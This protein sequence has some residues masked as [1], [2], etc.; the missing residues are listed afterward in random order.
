[1]TGEEAL[2]VWLAMPEYKRNL[3]LAIM[4]REI[5]KVDLEEAEYELEA[6]LA[7]RA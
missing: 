4:K 3:C 7:K 2:K 1:M 5:A 6:S